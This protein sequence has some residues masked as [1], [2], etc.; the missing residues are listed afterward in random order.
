M[1]IVCSPRIFTYT[2][3]HTFHGF[4]LWFNPNATT[5]FYSMILILGLWLW[6]SEAEKQWIIKASLTKHEGQ[7]TF[8]DSLSRPIKWRSESRASLL[9][10]ARSLYFE[11]FIVKWQNLNRMFYNKIIIKSFQCRPKALAKTQC[12]S[13]CLNCFLHSFSVFFNTESMIVHVHMHTYAHSCARARRRC[14]STIFIS[15]CLRADFGRFFGFCCDRTVSVIAS[16]GC[17]TGWVYGINISS[18]PG[19]RAISCLSRATGRSRAGVCFRPSGFYDKS[20]IYIHAMRNTDEH[21]NA[22]VRV[23]WSLMKY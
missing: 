6:R 3:R 19:T 21:P 16:A 2:H 7:S 17:G 8:H 10:H 13:L 4:C 14:R 11:R 15:A 20:F 9:A 5:L 1:W 23:K 18:S 22:R 12:V